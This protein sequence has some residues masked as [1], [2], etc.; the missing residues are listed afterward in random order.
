MSGAMDRMHSDETTGFP[1][2]PR[3][4]ICGMLPIVASAGIGFSRF[5][6]CMAHALTQID[7]VEPVIIGC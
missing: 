6:Y 1:W 2:K 3:W 4:R 7:P 5:S